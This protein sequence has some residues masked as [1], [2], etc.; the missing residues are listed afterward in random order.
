ML[1]RYE[2]LIASVESSLFSQEDSKAIKS[3]GPGVYA[4]FLRDPNALPTL[5]VSKD[6]VMYIG[7]TTSSLNER[8]HLFQRDS[9]FSSPRRSFGALLKFA[10]KSN[11]NLTVM[12]RGSGRSKG[13]ISNYRFSPEGEEKLTEWMRKN[14]T[15]RSVVLS[16]QIEIIETGLIKRNNPPLNL[17]HSNNLSVPE[18]KRLRK[19][20]RQE[21]QRNMDLPDKP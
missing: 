16:E 19:L 4:L 17:T 11:S 14:L 10:C 5:H 8:N 21:A 1:A 9:S 12:P 2:E 18:L 13:A 3:D 6:A 7:M 15:Y 20:C